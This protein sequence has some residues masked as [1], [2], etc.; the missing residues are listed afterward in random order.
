MRN[1]SREGL[2]V[3]WDGGFTARGY[4]KGKKGG[5]VVELEIR[6]GR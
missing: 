2:G 1:P 5:G 4:W 6:R 3:F